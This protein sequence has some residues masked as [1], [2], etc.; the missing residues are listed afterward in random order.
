MRIVWCCLDK[1]RNQL[2]FVFRE[3]CK[4]EADGRVVLQGIQPLD[5]V[6]L[7]TVP[8]SLSLQ[9]WQRDFTE[10][11]VGELRERGLVVTDDPTYRLESWAVGERLTLR[12]SPRSYFDSVLL[13][14]FPEWGLRSQVLAVVSV[15]ECL[16][17][18][19]V[20]RRSARVAALPG[21]LHPVPAGSIQP[22]AHPIETLLTEAREELGLE[23]QEVKEIQCLG[24]VYGEKS[25]V[26]QLVCRATV[27]LTLEQIAQRPCSGDWERDQ[28]FNVPAEEGPFR[29]W[30]DQRREA[31]TTAGRMALLMEGER[32]W[33]RELLP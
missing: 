8:S 13:K 12:V 11:A 31:L 2:D 23:P 1:E 19:L 16:D 14:R 6:V 20:E 7:E 25:G 10:L 5:G 29:A 17:G 28:I 9:G 32:R 26:Y 33:G 4:G 22:P 27:D 21:R 18:Y 15:T 30:I 24:L 3:V